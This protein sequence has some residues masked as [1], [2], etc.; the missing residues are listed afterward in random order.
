MRPQTVGLVL[1]SCITGV[2]LAA[3][4]FV[5]AWQ[6]WPEDRHQPNH[7]GVVHFGPIQVED[8]PLLN[9]GLA[10][11]NLAPLPQ[12]ELANLRGNAVAVNDYTLSEPITHG[13]LTVFLIHGQDALKDANIMTLEEA[14]TQN[15]AVVQEGWPVTVHNRSNV[16]LFV[17][18]GD[19]IKGG[20][21]D[22][23][24]PYD[25][26][27]P[28]LTAVKLN[29]WCVESGRSSP[30]GAEISTS[31]QTATEAVPTRKLKLAVFANQNAVWANVANTQNALTRNLGAKVNANQSPSSLQLTLEHPQ[32]KNA[33][34]NYV[35]AIAPA[36]AGKD[37]VIGYVVAVNGKVQS[38][39]VYAS[40]SL[41]MKLWPKLVRASAVD[42]LTERQG[43][44]EAA[45]PDADS[46][47]AFLNSAE[48]GQA[49]KVGSTHST[50]VR[51]ETGQ[52]LLHD[53]IVPNQNN[54][55]LHRSFLVK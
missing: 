49:S 55:V 34:Q 12:A 23:T 52:T 44:A 1:A 14:L 35:N 54:L 9:L 47:H 13:N 48:Q 7:G 37:D 4:C 11:A 42:A 10:N 40:S 41:F 18:S 43:N 36:T 8:A 27:I 51:Q 22:R 53:T 39:D 17:Q 32:L 45:P 15:Q 50:V 19:I 21:Q 26:L 3:V 6:N 24:I 25:S 38:A 29:A 16:P 28:P 20:N 33:V 5:L 31:F 30:R 2:F 46:V